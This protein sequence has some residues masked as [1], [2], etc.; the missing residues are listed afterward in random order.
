MILDIGIGENPRGDV[1]IDVTRTKYCNLIASAE[2]L[3]LK[4]TCM[5]KVLCSQVLEHL[6]NP[7]LALREMNRVLKSNGVAE[8]DILKPF[9]ASNSKYRLIELFLN[10]PFIFTPNYIKRLVV[11]LRG[12]KRQGPRWFHRYVITV[13]FVKK[14]LKVNNNGEFGDL[15][16]K[17]LT[18]GRKA[19]YFKKKPKINTK[20]LLRCSKK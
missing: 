16:L 17:P 1:N 11:S 13:D 3:P 14:F 7:T 6:S 10:S 20:M 4:N 5:D 9:F 19:K 18:C 8:I 2:H 12:V 15:F